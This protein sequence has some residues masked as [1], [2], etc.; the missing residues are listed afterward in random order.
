M[1]GKSLYI[2]INKKELPKNLKKNIDV[3][4]LNKYILSKKEKKYI[5]NI[6]PDPKKTALHSESIILKTHKVK[7]KIIE[8]IKKIK[9]F[10]DF[11]DLEELLDPF[12]EMKLSSHF[13]MNDIIPEYKSY[14]LIK[15]GD[16]INFNSKSD[17]ILSI[18]KIYSNEID[19][20]QILSK[21]SNLKFNFYNDK[22]LKIQNLILKT[23]LKSTTKDINFF[24]DKEAYFIKDLKKEIQNNKNINFYYTPTVSYLRIIQILFK[25]AFYL[26]FKSNFREIGMFILPSNYIYYD[27]CKLINNLDLFEIDEIEDKFLIY[28]IKQIY[29]N[30]LHSLGYQKYLTKIFKDIKIKK[31][32]FHSVRYSD[33][34]SFSKVLS[35]FN[36]NVYLISHGTHTIQKNKK[37]DLIASNSLGIGI[38]YTNTKSIKILSQSKYCDDYLDFLKIKYLKI[39]RLIQKGQIYKEDKTFSQYK[40]QTKILFVGTVKQLGARRY[41]VESSAEFIE[42]VN[43]LYSKL[44]KYKNIF[45][46][47]ISIRDVNNEINYEILRNAFKSKNDLIELSNKNSIYQE[48]KNC[49]CL[50]SH[51]STTLEEGLYFN[52]PVMSFGLPKYDHLTSYEKDLKK[53]KNLKVSK[54]LKIIEMSLGRKFIH[55]NLKE[56]KIDHIF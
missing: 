16:F 20:D 11:N 1:I 28:I 54:N 47:K 10:K 51:S 18:E 2:I 52:K 19:K 50:I 12:L 32:Y 13:Y 40:S 15:N 25:Q 5:N 38:T 7:I 37:V 8:K 14:I 31:S 44:N 45:K 21:F 17:L 55:N 23:L 6:F 9:L 35:N 36:T 56:R 22:L 39:N 4:T 29:C 53:I 43:L 26:L 49:D 24:S 30:I 3:F 34:F 41:Y 27:Y 48:I 33:L 46:I 42:S